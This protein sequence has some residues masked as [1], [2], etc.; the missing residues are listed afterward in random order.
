M[1]RAEGTQRYGQQQPC[2]L[3]FHRA[4][5]SCGLRPAGGAVVMIVAE[6]VPASRPQIIITDLR[7]IDAASRTN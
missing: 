7:R 4:T 1:H 3:E 2:R 6:S 5:R